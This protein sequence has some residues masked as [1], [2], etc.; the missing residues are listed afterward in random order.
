MRVVE[1]GVILEDIRLKTF[2]EMV[3]VAN[4]MFTNLTEIPRTK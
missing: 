2:E 4:Q 3:Q 1:K